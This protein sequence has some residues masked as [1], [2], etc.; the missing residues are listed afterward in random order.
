M[1]SRFFID[2]PIFATVLSVAITL[3]GTISLLVLPIAQ[4]PRITPPGVSISISYPGASAQEVADSVGAPI[5]QQVNGVAGMLYMASQSGNDGSYT[6][7]VTF[8][9]GTDI[10]AAL[11]M[12]QNRVALAM[13]QL[14]SA[15][16][17]QGITIRKRTPDMLMI[18]NFVSPDG[19]YDDKYL[20]NFATIYAKDELLRVDGISDINVQGQRDYS[21]R[22]WLDP[23]RL[24]ARNLTPL[25]VANAI[26]TQNVDAPAG[27]IGQPPAPAGQAFQL[28]LNTLGRL[29]GPEQFSKIVVATGGTPPK[30]SDNGRVFEATPPAPP[31][32]AKA[33]AA[34][35]MTPADTGATGGSLS[36][37]TATTAAPMSVTTTP[38]DTGA[39]LD[40][41]P[42]TSSDPAAGGGADPGN[43]T[44]SPA[45]MAAAPASGASAALTQT[46]GPS[47]GGTVGAG[48]LGGGALAA[49]TPSPSTPLVRLED[50]ARIELGA[51]NYNTICSFDGRPSVGLGLYQ[52]PGTNAL[53]VADRVRAKMEELKT[54]FPDGVDYQIAYDTTPFI[55]DS[56]GDVVRT[57]VEAVGLVAIVVLVFLQSWRAALIP[58]LA[59]PVAVL[60]T[61]A[62]MAAMGFS[63][64]NISLFG[65]VLAIGIVVDDAIVVVENVERWMDRGLSPRDATYRAMDEVT[66]PIVAVALVL[67]AVFV[68]C[69]FIKGITGQF[70]RQFA[71]TIAVS[72]VISTINSLTFSPAIAAILLRPRHA[73]QDVLGRL[74][75]FAFG[76]FFWVF[77]W[78]SGLGTA[79]YAWVIGGLM[80][81]AVLV[82]LV[83]AGLL[84]L[85]VWTFD[86]A[87]K[88]FIPQQDQGRLIVNV[89]LSDAASLERT[90][91]TVLRVEQIARETPGVAHTITNSG[92]SFLLQSNSPNFA[93]MFIVLEP[94]SARQSPDKKDQA[95]MARLRK[96][97]AAEVPDAQVTVFGAAP[98]PGLGS[99]GGFKFMVEDRGGLGVRSLE[100]RMDDLVDQFKKLPYL[101]DAKTQFR[102]RIPQLYLE[103]DRTKAA[104]LGVQ[105]QD[106]NQTVSMYLGSLY[107]NSYNDFGRHWQVTVQADGDFRT[108]PEQIHLFQVRSSSG[109]MI[110]L[111]TLVRVVDKAGPISVTRYNLYTSAP[112]NGNVLAG[113]SDGD[114]IAAINRVADDTL[115]R[116]MRVEWTEL[117]FMQLRAGNTAIY[118]FLLSVVSVF[119][120]LAAL[121]ESWSL[122]LAVIL[123][124]PLCLLCSVAGVLF[125]NRDVNIFVQIGLVVLVGLACKNAILIVEFAKHLHTQGKSCF[126]ATKEASRL[127]LRPIVMTSFAFIFGVLPLMTASGAGAEMRRSLGIAVFSGM[128]GVTVFG[129][130]L[131]PVFFYVVQGVGE[132]RLFRSARVRAALSY[133]TGAGLGATLGFLLGRLGT[134]DPTWGP[135]V[136]GAAGVLL[137][138]GGLSARRL[139]GRTLAGR[140]ANWRR[141][142]PGR[143]PAAAPDVP[144]S[145]STV[146]LVV[147]APGPPDGPPA[148]SQNGVHHP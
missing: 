124:V 64:N 81:V 53:D 88:G 120:A 95:I 50:L 45:V 89:Q 86:Q 93:S 97:W 85:T 128:L 72:T 75:N 129:I 48:A 4:Y 79:L 16:Q 42:D 126:D 36:G 111:S 21:M 130:F 67:C 44:G 142:D 94:F 54:G 57:L 69:A 11:V 105:V 109:Q 18:V 61:F 113:V 29:A 108:R 3:T 116:S 141:P 5:E 115:P 22:V 2:R 32:R 24:A 133:L 35:T 59:V 84:V 96:R 91:D 33:A 125:T 87:P 17:N 83:Y 68:P 112:I 46:T 136:G 134:V 78:A 49:P 145:G 65:L 15:V 118:V 100:L 8:D 131:T 123:V 23:Q 51:Q 117:M 19:R 38:A 30:Y 9:I 92:M 103:V 121:Y 146:A 7:T 122:P 1:L 60:G 13:P 127:R 70:F 82:L 138:R 40:S 6:L 77:N 25:D 39:P 26:R 12:V 90:Y 14:P 135:V 55:R 107:V 58:L 101:A 66:G 20:S 144:A 137:I 119:L 148:P 71:V 34:A 106:L 73:R 43:P 99:A 139:A 74:L 140:S 63:L 98:V 10:N 56:I 147:H 62:V 41:T 80:R 28:P 104:A 132:T 37:S 102:S 110:P 27:R 52:L 31:K 114:A 143:P 47:A 76:W